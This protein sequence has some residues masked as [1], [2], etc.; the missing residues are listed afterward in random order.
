MPETP[1]PAAPDRPRRDFEPT[2]AAAIARTA[3]GLTNDVVLL[4][5]RYE[6]AL[7][8]LALWMDAEPDDR[9]VL[10]VSTRSVLERGGREVPRA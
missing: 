10:L 7:D 4:C 5:S 8:L 3:N 6:A 9:R 1:D 2:D